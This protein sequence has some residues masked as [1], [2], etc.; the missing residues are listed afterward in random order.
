M[1]FEFDSRKSLSNKR[2]H[3]IDF[4]EAQ[5]LWD[6]T[7]HVELPGRTSDESQYVV[8]GRIEGK[9]CSGIVTYR[10]ERVRIISV[11]C[12]RSEEVEIYEG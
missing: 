5:R 9:H 4:I 12:A 2:K 11:R 3:G 6:D 10:G 1:E 8:I 7:T